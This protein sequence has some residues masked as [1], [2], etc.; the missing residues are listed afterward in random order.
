MKGFCRLLFVNFTTKLQCIIRH[1]KKKSI[2]ETGEK[3]CLSAFSALP[4]TFSKDVK[5]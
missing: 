1:E 5:T 2:V 3:C 4:I